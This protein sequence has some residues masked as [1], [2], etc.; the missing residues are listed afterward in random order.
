MAD[1]EM[2]NFFFEEVLE[3]FPKWEA[4]CLRLEQNPV[5]TDFDELFRYA[6]NIKGSSKMVRLDSLGNFVHKVEDVINLLREKKLQL[7]SEHIDLFLDV[8][9]T[10]ESWLEGLGKDL[11]FM[12]DVA[13]VAARISSILGTG[14]EVVHSAST[15]ISRDNIEILAKTDAAKAINNEIAEHLEIDKSNEQKVKEMIVEMKKIAI[16]EEVGAVL[17]VVD[18]LVISRLKAVMDK[19]TLEESGKYNMVLKMESI[20]TAGIQWLL[21]LKKSTQYSVRISCQTESVLTVLR[22]L[23]VEGRLL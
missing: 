8:H 12:P 11:A 9:T 3:M 2:L 15:E 17:E 14:V 16:T 5:P 10:L 20:D 6:H 22:E 21:A 18:D 19:I 23:G 1:N 13:D 7:S 4:V